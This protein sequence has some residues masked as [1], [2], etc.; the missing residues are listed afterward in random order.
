VSYHVIGSDNSENEN[1]VKPKGNDFYDPF[2]LSNLD[3][4]LIV[5][6][7]TPMHTLV[8]NKYN[9]ITNHVCMKYTY[10]IYNIYWLID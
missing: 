3:I 1:C 2:D 4:N 8:L 9:T 7:I 6:D 10:I 5:T